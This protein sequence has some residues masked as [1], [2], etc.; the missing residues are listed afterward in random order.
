MVTI[1]PTFLPTF[2]KFITCM[3]LELQTLTNQLGHLYIQ[4]AYTPP[5]TPDHTTQ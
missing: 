2:V 5:R 3:Y 1:Q 4:C